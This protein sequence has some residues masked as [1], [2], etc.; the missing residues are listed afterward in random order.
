M[1]HHALSRPIAALPLRA[2]NSRTF[3]C[4]RFACSRRLALGT[5]DRAVTGVVA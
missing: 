3:E 4:A 2:L 1:N 5:G